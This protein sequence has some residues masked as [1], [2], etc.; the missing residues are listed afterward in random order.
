MNH[1]LNIFSHV[2]KKDKKVILLIV[3]TAREE[4]LREFKQMAQQ[5]GLKNNI[6]FTGW[7]DTNDIPQYIAAADVGIHTAIYDHELNPFKVLEYMAAG[8]P[9]IGSYY[10]LRELLKNSQGGILIHP[11]Q[12]KESAEK[13]ITLLNNKKLMQE[14]GKNARDYVVEHHDW[15]KNIK[16]LHRILATLI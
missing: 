5:L 11:Q 14:M 2:I 15:Q 9:I 3:G 13:I 12:Y 7:V 1:I 6:I 16:Q 4:L 10:G 8:K